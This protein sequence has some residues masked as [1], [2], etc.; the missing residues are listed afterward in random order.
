MPVGGCLLLPAPCNHTCVLALSTCA[1]DAEPAWRTGHA[2]EVNA[3]NEKNR[4][5]I[6]SQS[7]CAEV[8]LPLCSS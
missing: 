7:R 5:R 2:A 1:V 8:E 3:L 6:K 4:V